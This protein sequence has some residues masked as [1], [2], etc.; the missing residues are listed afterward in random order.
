[1]N[2]TVVGIDLTVNRA[3]LR[4]I[5]LVTIRVR[6]RSNMAGILKLSMAMA[7]VSGIAGV[8]ATRSLFGPKP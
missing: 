2:T 4:A 7:V 3:R 1:M 6:K 8:V 5:Q